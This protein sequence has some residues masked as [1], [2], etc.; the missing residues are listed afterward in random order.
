MPLGMDIT[1]EMLRRSIGSK[2]EEEGRVSLGGWS[3]CPIE[4]TI[5]ERDEYGV[6]CRQESVPAGPYRIGRASPKVA[7]L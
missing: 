6:L 5:S 2:D 4:S 1:M 3:S 7:K